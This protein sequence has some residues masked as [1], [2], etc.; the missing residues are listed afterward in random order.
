MSESMAEERRAAEERAKLAQMEADMINST[1]RMYT[2][3]QGLSAAAARGSGRS[4]TGTGTNL[5]GV[6]GSGTA[7]FLICRS[8]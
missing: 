6:K 8:N 4:Y 3:E 7:A 5:P 1:R 2:K